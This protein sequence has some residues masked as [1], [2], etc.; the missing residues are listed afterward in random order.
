MRLAYSHCSL[1]L[2]S[3]AFKVCKP[4]LT[5]LGLLSLVLAY[6]PLFINLPFLLYLFKS[7]ILQSN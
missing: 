6:Y 1:P 4:C 2:I 3:S 5:S 7:V